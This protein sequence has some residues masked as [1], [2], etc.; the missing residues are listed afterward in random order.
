MHN[1]DAFLTRFEGTPERT[2]RWI[3][4]VVLAGPRRILFLICDRFGRPV[5][6]IGLI[7]RPDKAAVEVDNVLRGADNVAPGIMTAALHALLDWSRA[8][9]DAEVALLRV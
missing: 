8:Q 6:Q 2:G 7:E 1:Q 3:R 5:G 9:T 4:S